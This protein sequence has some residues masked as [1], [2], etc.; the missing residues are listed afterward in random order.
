MKYII[1]R[2]ANTHDEAV[3]DWSEDIMEEQ[4]INTSL[5]EN[6]IEFEVLE[7]GKLE[8]RGEMVC[9][10]VKFTYMQTGCTYTSTAEVE[11]E[12]CGPLVVVHESSGMTNCDG[13]R[14]SATLAMDL[15]FSVDG[16]KAALAQASSLALG[17]TLVPMIINDEYHGPVLQLAAAKEALARACST[18]EPG[19]MQAV[20]LAGANSSTSTLQLTQR[21]AI[22][23]GVAI[24]PILSTGGLGPIVQGR[25]MQDKESFC[26]DMVLPF[27]ALRQHHAFASAHPPSRVPSWD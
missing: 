8:L 7:D 3:K 12:K 17:T 15:T 11:R 2:G 21:P 27:P 18:M 9:V 13:P 22:T 4:V 1:L 16:F 5:S 20:V 24:C 25:E 26:V 14:R 10:N 19:W 6:F 23:L